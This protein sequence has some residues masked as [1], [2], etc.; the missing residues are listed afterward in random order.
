[1]IMKSTSRLDSGDGPSSLAQNQ[2]PQ[3]KI[4][5]TGEN[6]SKTAGLERSAKRAAALHFGGMELVASPVDEV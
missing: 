3:I 6:G 4:Y 2:R 5:A 1:M